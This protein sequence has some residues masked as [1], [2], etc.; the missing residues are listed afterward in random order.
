M[1]KTCPK[2]MRLTR[3]S[4]PYADQSDT[5]GWLAKPAVRAG[6]RRRQI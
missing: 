3:E 4:R 1:P 6:L 2:W 5:A